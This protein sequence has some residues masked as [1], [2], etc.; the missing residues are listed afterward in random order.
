MGDFFDQTGQPLTY[1]AFNLKFNVNT[2]NFLL[3]HGCLEAIRTYRRR[4]DI[5]LENDN[6]SSNNSLMQKIISC[7]SGAKSFYDALCDKSEPSFCNKWNEKLNI[8]VN[9]KTAFDNISK[10]KE[11]KLR[12]FQL[13]IMNRII[14]TN[15]TLKAMKIRI[16][17]LC[18]FC[19]E[20][21][22]TIEHLF[23]ECMFSIQFW[24]NVKTL[25][26]E[27]NIVQNDF[28]L[29]QKCIL[30]GISEYLTSKALLYFIQVAKY[31]I[32][33]SR[34]EECIPIF[35]TFKV[36]FKKK[37]QIIR[38]IAMKNNALDQFDIE[39]ELWSNLTDA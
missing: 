36:Y 16:D 37:F 5:T 12:W 13:R 17:D 15:V 28:V 31:F 19:N 2:P 32:Y 39:W 14:G 27:N 25:L 24:N 21:T 38:Y 29:D 30:F 23:T 3:Y 11:I 6:V 8:N 10:M 18:T 26:V 22:E 20:E 1:G 35:E 9:W 34:C 33:K 7:P 4:L